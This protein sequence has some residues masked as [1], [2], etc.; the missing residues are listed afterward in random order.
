MTFNKHVLVVGNCQ[1]QLFTESLS[2]VGRNIKCIGHRYRRNAFEELVNTVRNNIDSGYLPL[3]SS[4]LRMDTKVI[5]FLTSDSGTP[6]I[7]FP[8]I[9]FGAF[10]PDIQFAQCGGETVRN[11]L[12]GAW[13]SRL[14][15]TSF[16]KGLSEHQTRELFCH[17]AFKAA[18]Y[19]DRWV[20]DINSLS[21]TFEFCE[22]DFPRWIRS[23]RRLGVF[24]HGVNHPVKGALQSLAHQMAEKIALPHRSTI[25]IARYSLDNLS[26]SVWPVYPEIAEHL[27]F[28]GSYVFQHQGRYAELEDFISSCFKLWTAQNLSTELV[29]TIPR[30]GFSIDSV[31]E[32]IQ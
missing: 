10:H 25:D 30:N 4:S 23:V 19:F 15:L 26:T 7:F 8:S 6:P 16:L 24:M 2:L 28:N 20:S 1:T 22:L 27:G 5:E 9:T 21:N 17:R 11:G 14:I 32:S 12:G 31:I 29:Q 13:N 18:G 3:L